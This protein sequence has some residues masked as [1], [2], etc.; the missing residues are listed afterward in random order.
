MGFKKIRYGEDITWELKGLDLDGKKLEKWKFM[1]CDFPKVIKI[2]NKKY[3][4]GM[5]IK[6]KNEDKDLDWALK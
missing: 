3:G 2:I 5:Y 4:M 1:N 6:I